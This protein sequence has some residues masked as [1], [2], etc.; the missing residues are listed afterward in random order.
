MKPTHYYVDE[1]G[2]TVL[3]G[4]HG[5]DLL[6]SKKTTDFL[7]LGR[8]EVANPIQLELDINALRAKLLADP[9]ISTVPSMRPE[10]RKTA[11]HFHAKDDIPE[12]RHAVFKL[13]LRHEL[14]M[15]AVVLEKNWLLQEVKQRQYLDPGY[16]YK[17]NGHDVYDTM[18][19]KLF[20]RSEEF[21]VARDITFAV[22]GNKPRTDSL[23]KVLDSI[24]ASYESDLGYR[25]NSQTVVRSAYPKKSAGL[26]ACDY[27]LWAL[28]R[29]Y[30]HEEERYLRA[31]WSK[32]ARVLDLGAPAPHTSGLPTQGGVQFDQNLPLT[33]TTRSGS[34]KR[35]R[36]I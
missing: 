25:P 27:L 11:T 33:L 16:R 23:R 6:E 13:L 17:S 9:L 32:F 2:D 31:V 24:D 8:L 3:F 15:V 28:S 30:E 21:G 14:Q 12:V 4:K 18:V 1:S 36:E 34:W 22:R 29:F 5:E 19:W 20:D 10:N 35:G 7:I 26:Q